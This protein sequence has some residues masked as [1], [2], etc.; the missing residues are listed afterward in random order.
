MKSSEFAAMASAAMPECVENSIAIA[1]TDALPANIPVP[2]L[3]N[4]RAPGIKGESPP[5]LSAFQVKVAA[6][7]K[8][9]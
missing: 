6:C 7:I 9:C 1:A 8:W 3:A 5:M 2:I 4:M